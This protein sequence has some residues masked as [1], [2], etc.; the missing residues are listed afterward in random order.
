DLKH[1]IIPDLLSFIFAFFALLGMFL[2][3][4]GGWWP[5]VPTG[6]EFLSGI[7]LALPFALLWLFSKG[8]WMGL[9]DAKLALGIGWFLGLPLA[10]SAI[11]LSFWI[12]A[13]VGIMIA[14]FRKGFGM[15][16]EIPFALFM[17]LG[18]FLAFMFNIN[19]FPISW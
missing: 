10:L 16:S 12:G 6:M 7:L 19:L 1:K 8:E 17:A 2:F 5:H 9:G 11:V 15:K 13:F 18:T 14:L 3:S 4:G